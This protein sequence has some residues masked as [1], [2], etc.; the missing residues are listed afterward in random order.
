L[1]SGF[2]K[3]IFGILHKHL[4]EK[5]WKLCKLHKNGAT[6]VGG[7]PTKK[8]AVLAAHHHLNEVVNIQNQ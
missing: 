2:G 8:W 7:A 6:P 5:W 1:S 3:I 4:R